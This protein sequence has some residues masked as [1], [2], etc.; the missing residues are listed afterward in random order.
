MKKII[1]KTNE[2]DKRNAIAKLNQ[3]R[4]N[5]LPA[6]NAAYAKF[7]EE[8]ELAPF[9][10]EKLKGVME[11]GTAMVEREL[12]EK[13]KTFPKLTQRQALEE[14]YKAINHILRP[15]IEGFQ[16]WKER[17]APS[18]G[19][20]PYKILDVDKM[21]IA[22]DLTMT[23]EGVSEYVEANSSLFE[24]SIND[25]I[26]IELFKRH[27]ALTEAFNDFMECVRKNDVVMP[28]NLQVIMGIQGML[29]G[30]IAKPDPTRFLPHMT[31]AK[32]NEIL[33][34]NRSH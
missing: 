17:L 29:N 20:F 33:N 23:S 26:D 8:T 24:V 10:K 6:I 9:S 32:R 31:N 1:I 30:R 27:N 11:Q 34:G 15:V 22:A 5:Q 4:L 7:V 25:P 28:E 12:E 21:P 14:G 19:S 13:I 2:A 18:D 3:F 16:K